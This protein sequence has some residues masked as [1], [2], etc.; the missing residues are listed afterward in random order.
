MIILSFTRENLES[1]ENYTKEFLF[2]AR[3]YVFA[4]M[5]DIQILKMLAL[6]KLHSTFFNCTLYKSRVEDIV[7][8]LRYVYANTSCG[9]GD[10]DLR[11][12]LTNYMN[13]EMNILIK[14]TKFKNLM[15]E[16]EEELLDDFMKMIIIRIDWW[17]ENAWNEWR[18]TNE[19]FRC[20]IIF[21]SIFKGCHDFKE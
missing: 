12:L 17:Y 18:I 1:N 20:F 19:V 7:A 5:Y 13:C 9:G 11:K 21:S 4:E 15:I 3:L 8:L 6:E 14:D 16:N 2:H 10:G